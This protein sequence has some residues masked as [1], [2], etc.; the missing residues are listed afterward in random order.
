MPWLEWVGNAFS[1]TNVELYRNTVAFVKGFRFSHTGFDGHDV[2]AIFRVQRRLP[3]G[4]TNPDGCRN[5]SPTICNGSRYGPKVFAFPLSNG[6][7]IPWGRTSPE[8]DRGVEPELH[9]SPTVHSKY[10]LAS[11]DVD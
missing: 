3:L 9:G 4:L 2:A 10:P 8:P 7:E 1:W 11:A 6:D 5:H